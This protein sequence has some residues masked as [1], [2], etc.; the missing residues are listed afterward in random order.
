MVGVHDGDTLTGLTTDRR[1][2]KV[3]LEGIDAPELGQPFGKAAK[4][5]LSGKAFGRSAEIVVAGR[6]QYGRVVARVTVDGLDIGTALVREGYAWCDPRF[7]HDSRLV[8]LE[9]T[10]RGSKVGLWADRDPTPPWEFRSH[11]GKKG[12]DSKPSGRWFWW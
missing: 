9:G 3:R 7:N 8:A 12:A 11:R 2:V 5:A 4:R 1:Q 6:D 10:A